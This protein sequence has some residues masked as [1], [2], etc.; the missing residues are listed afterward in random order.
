MRMILIG[1]YPPDK[2]ESMERFAQ[3][4]HAEFY[5]VGIQVDIWRPT[6]FF[7]HLANWTI[8]GLGKW[9]GYIDK[10]L[11]FPMVLV[12]RL[13]EANF[14]GSN[15]R[16][17]VCDQGNA[18]YLKFLPVHRTGITCHDVLAIRGAL[19]F[20]DAYTPATATG[21]IFQQWIFYHLSKSSCLAS[22]TENTLKQLVA[23]TSNKSSAIEQW[24]VV[25]NALNN[26]FKPLHNSKYEELLIKAGLV[27]DIPFILHVGSNDIRKN[28]K[29]LIDMVDCLRDQWTGL[30]CFAGEAADKSL[31]G[32][33]ES[34]GLKNRI[35][36][37]VKPNHETLVSLYNACF[38]FI[39]PS[40]S[41]GFGWPLIEAQACGAAVITSNIEPLPEV[42]GAGALYAD[43]YKPEE[44]A[45]AFVLI[46]SKKIRFKLIERGFRNSKRFDAG[47]M[48][49]SYLELHG[50]RPLVSA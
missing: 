38:A 6:V 28:R 31:I 48:A 29:L 47:K 11:I 24:R 9:L 32:Y 50:I 8:Y 14:R 1:N 27:P 42:G 19:G 30:I 5:K 33:A 34:L 41:E 23:L 40:F 16:F 18:P 7:G 37:I 17:H 22:V 21:K 36:S 20:S 15:V 39:F 46:K 45:K 25:H 4:L 49:Y 43:P 3:L 12:I 13:R 10:F 35:I 2:L 26:D 44:F